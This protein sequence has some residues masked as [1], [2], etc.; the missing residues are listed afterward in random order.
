MARRL[1]IPKDSGVIVL[2]LTPD[3]KG[4]TAGIKEGDVIAEI[5]H[6][7]V[8]SVNDLKTS[9]EKVKKGDVISLLIERKNASLIVIKLTK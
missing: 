9:I 7:P 1:N 2:G 6:N 3:G 4:D 5:N 8:K